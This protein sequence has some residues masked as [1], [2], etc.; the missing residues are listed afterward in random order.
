[1]NSERQLEFTPSAR[2]REK[3]SGIVGVIVFK[4]DGDEW[5]IREPDGNVTVCR[6]DNLTLCSPVPGS[7]G[8]EKRESQG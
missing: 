3:S 6:E 4:W 7:D 1:M 2:V 8:G 5:V